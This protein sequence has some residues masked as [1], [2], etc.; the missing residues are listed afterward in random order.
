MRTAPVARS[1]TILCS[2][3]V[4]RIPQEEFASIPTGGPEL[5]EK[6]N[7]YSDKNIA[8]VQEFPK[9][10]SGAKDFQDVVRT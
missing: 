5:G 10:L 9:S 3:S 6:L 4:L 2:V 8:S 7:E 1:S